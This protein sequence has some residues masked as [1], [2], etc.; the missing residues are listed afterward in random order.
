MCVC[1]LVCVNKDTYQCVYNLGWVGWERESERKRKRRKERKINT[2]R[3][4]KRG[5][6]RERVTK[7]EN[8]LVYI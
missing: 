3:E 6:E 8:V 7:R 2:K 5:R 4:R 1:V